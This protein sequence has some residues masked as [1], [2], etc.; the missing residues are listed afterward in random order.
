MSRRSPVRL[1]LDLPAP[2]A[3][4]C[5]AA[6]LID[7]LINVVDA[8]E[9]G[10]FDAVM[11]PDHT[12]MPDMLGG[13]SAPLFEPLT[14]LAA[15]AARTER[16]G[17]ATSV[18]ANG[19]RNPALVAKAFTSLDLIAPGR[20]V[21]GIGAGWYPPDFTS[22]GKSFAAPGDRVAMLDEALTIIRSL[23]RGDETTVHGRWHTTDAARNEPRIGGT[24]P[25]IVVGAS[26][27][28]MLELAVR[29]GDGVNI[30][31]E[32]PALAGRVRALE[33][34]CREHDR[35]RDEI[36]VTAPVILLP[37]EGDAAPLPDDHPFA[38]R[39]FRG[40]LPSLAD[41]VMAHVQ[42]SRVD[43]VHVVLAGERAA[44]PALVRSLGEVLRPA[45]TA[46][47]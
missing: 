3:F 35:D 42:R 21:L 47:R 12:V 25:P 5:A 2:A 28:R 15:I 18:L 36:T 1:G 23:L 20:S 6:S 7:E 40:D 39:M 8:A 11:V 22:I 34:I 26:G 14:T 38:T 19:L 13:P 43:G 17:F 46:D 24:G 4:S 30:N 27:D 16:I 29:R 10:G 33:R 31:C 9:V 37:A 45:I 41:Q 32:L 44:D